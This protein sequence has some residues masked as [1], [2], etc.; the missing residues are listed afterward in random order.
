M[1]TKKTSSEQSAT[2]TPASA[3]KW[4]QKLLKLDGAIQRDYDPHS[5]VI[6]SPS[7]SIN[8][9]YGKNWGIPLGYT[10]VKFGPP[11]G[12]KTVLSNF[13]IGQYHHDYPDGIAIRF[14]TE[15]RDEASL[16]DEN[17]RLFGIDPARLISFSVNSPE[18][19][20]DKFNNDIVPMMQDMEEKE[21][22]NKI[23]FI[24]IDSITGIM[25]RRA[26]NQDTISTQQ[27]GDLALTLQEGFKSV[28]K[29]QRKYRV[30][31]SLIA[32]VRAE[33]DALEQKKGN[34]V[35]MAASFGIK[36]YAEYFT[37]VER[38]DTADGRMDLLGN[39]FE[40][41][42]RAR[43]L[44]AK[45]GK[46]EL[47]AHRIR[48]TMKDNTFGPKGRVGAFTFDYKK[49]IVNTHEEVFL[50]G[51]SHGVLGRPTNTSYTYKDRSW[52]GKPKMLEALRDDR[53]LYD[54]VLADVKA[55]D[56]GADGAEAEEVP[57]LDEV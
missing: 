11:K 28:L 17:L 14:D 56:R 2:P 23:R 27:I 29:S 52:H 49:G 38:Y 46:G 6:R 57:M 41:E 19:V 25:G 33:M 21:G 12:G 8:F 39:D 9:I 42:D 55:Q 45:D 37:F 5:Q 22:G 26:M 53:A 1:A 15:M 13:Q 40:N 47:T 34:K 7:P 10:E 20:F 50:L 44:L 51:T 35:K 16:T 48:V 24:V 18:E 32:H 3:N 30:F 4:M 36:H 54:A 43:D 31:F